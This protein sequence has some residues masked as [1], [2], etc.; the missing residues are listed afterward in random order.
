[1]PRDTGLVSADAQDDFLRA[2]RANALAR[3]GQ[4]LRREPGDVNLILPF[5]EVVAGARARRASTTL[6]LQVIA[7][8]SIVGHGRPHAASSTASSGPP[9][10]GCARRWERIAAAMRRGEAMPP[11]SVY[12]VGELHFVRDG[13]HRVSVARAHAAGH[14]IDAYVTE[15]H[16]RVGAERAPSRSPTCRSRATSGSSASACPLAARGARAHRARP[17]RG[18]TATW[19]RA[20]RR[21]AF[22]AMQDARR[23]HGPRRRWRAPGSSDEYVPV[24]EMLARPTCI[25]RGHRD[26]RLPARRRR[27]LPPAAHARLER[28]RSLA[29]LRSEREALRRGWLAA[30]AVGVRRPARRA[31]RPR[32]CPPRARRRLAPDSGVEEVQLGGVEPELGLL[33]LRCTL[34]AGSRRATIWLARRSRAAPRRRPASAASSRELVGLRRA[35]PRRG[36]RRRARSPS[37]RAASISASKVTRAALARRRRARRPRSPRAGRRR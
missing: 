24:V 19:P 37:T 26:R 29:R 1:M 22:R 32:R 12:R 36:S 34:L 33:A 8:D 23:V 28:G 27:A 7:L 21:G 31:R 16:T 3:L 6:G 5:E 20:S 30:C 17:T 13:H 18:A 10:T 14:D 2:R 4:R 35:R 11:I 9:P 15:V 25:G